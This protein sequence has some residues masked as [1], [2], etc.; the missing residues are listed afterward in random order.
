VV[1]VSSPRVVLGAGE[2]GEATIL[3]RIAEGFRI[4]AN[5]AS[6]PFLVPARLEIEADDHVEAGAPV[7]PPGEPYRL[8]GAAEE[9][10]VYRGEVLIRLPLGARRPPGGESGETLLRG[11]LHYQACNARMCL[12]PS[13]VPVEVRVSVRRTLPR[14]DEAGHHGR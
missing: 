6:D 14:G 9:L 7:Y 8:E 3:A 11:R 10:S 13:S 2:H 4:Q 1:T 5:P 12:R